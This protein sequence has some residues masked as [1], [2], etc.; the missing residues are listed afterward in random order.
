MA[1]FETRL[2]TYHANGVI[3]VI[4][5]FLRSLI[6][7]SLALL[8][9]NPV[10]QSKA[11]HRYV[12]SYCLCLLHHCVILYLPK[13]VADISFALGN[14]PNIRVNIDAING[15]DTSDFTELIFSVSELN[16]ANNS[17]L[18]KVSSHEV[19]GALNQPNILQGFQQKHS[20]ENLSQRC[21]YTDDQVC[22]S[23]LCGQ[24]S[25][26][27]TNIHLYSYANT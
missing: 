14:R 11:K 17:I 21:T 5:S 27:S 13:I 9:R 10:M 23:T 6:V 3:D 15:Y 19:M 12:Q 25:H 24:A 20:I 4:F 2:K 16:P 26:V 18:R 7:S 22:F 1:I 8:E